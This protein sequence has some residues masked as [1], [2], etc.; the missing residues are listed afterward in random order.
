MKQGVP[1]YEPSSPHCLDVGGRFISL[2]VHPAKDVS[3]GAD[4]WHGGPHL[5]RSDPWEVS[6]RNQGWESQGSPCESAMWDKWKQPQIS[7]REV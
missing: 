7:S 1:I 4:L 2:P 5:N 3:L 6:V